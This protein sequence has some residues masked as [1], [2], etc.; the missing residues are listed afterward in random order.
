M[1]SE[2][3]S[4]EGSAI[5][6]VILI[7]LVLAGDNAIVVGMAAAGV[8]REDRRRVIMWGVVAAVVLRI[9]FAVVTVQL[10]A[11]IGLTLAGGL[12]LLWVCWK[13]YR[14]LAER[15]QE[16]IGADMLDADAPEA[17][18]PTKTV[19]TAIW[20]VALA[21]I[22]MSLD[23][24]LAVAGAAGDQTTALIIGLIFSV[25]LMGLAANMIAHLLVRHHWIGYV[26]LLL[27]GW[28]A[29]AMIWRGAM[30]V[31]QAAGL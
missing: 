9:A 17:A 1:F 8:P 24:V 14:E 22:T 13:L 28:V 19:R 2:F 21:D 3:F 5:I 31:A 23:N 20:Q 26:G 30:E 4:S 15:R 10:L 6:Q 16:D 29:G 27:I 7:D 25:I 11:V 18:G 12:L